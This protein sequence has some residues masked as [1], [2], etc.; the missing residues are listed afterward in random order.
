[1]HEVLAPFVAAAQ[2]WTRTRSS[3][4][5]VREI[6]DADPVGTGDVVAGGDSEPGLELDDVAIGWPGAP[7]I[8][9]GLNLVVRPG[10]KVACTGAS[11]IGKTTLAATAMGLIPTRAGTV[12]RGGRVGYLAQDA[13]IFATSV[14]ENVRIGNKDATDDQVRDALER[15]G[16]PLDPG[17]LVGEDGGTLSGGER[18]RLALA[19]L[20]V[21]DRDLWILDE[22]TEHLDQATAE[23]L[24]A[25]VW[26]TSTGRAVLVIS[27]D[28]AVVAACDRELHLA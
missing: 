20:L 5:R 28:P 4:A 25:D 26:R 8:Q 1:V 18:R 14:A 11:G 3:L 15:A 9:T 7:V 27:H 12:R 2:T 13:H 6:L 10:Q 23:A 22:P 19:R 17:R 16:L 24:M 21:A